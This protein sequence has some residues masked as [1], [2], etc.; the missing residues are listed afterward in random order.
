VVKQAALPARRVNNALTP[1]TPLL[2]FVHPEP[3]KQTKARRLLAQI[4]QQVISTA[5]EF[6]AFIYREKVA[7]TSQPVK[8]PRIVANAAPDIIIQALVRL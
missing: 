8:A 7:D 1:P 3:S 6:L 4:A 5:C 2:K